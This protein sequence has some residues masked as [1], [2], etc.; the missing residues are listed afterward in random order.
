MENISVCWKGNNWGEET[1][2]MYYYYMFF[3]N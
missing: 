3:S 1:S 2:G